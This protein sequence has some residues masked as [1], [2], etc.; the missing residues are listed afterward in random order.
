MP[1]LPLTRKSVN[2]DNILLDPNN[3]RFL[4]LEDW[5]E[6]PINMY[7]LERIQNTAFQRLDGADFAQIEDLRK[8]IRANGYIPLEMIVVKPYEE[9][10]SKYVVIEG[11]RRITAIRGIV[12]DSV[13]PDEDS[14]VQSLRT[15]E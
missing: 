7:H 5:Q 9:D 2:L 11:N 14:L 12:K 3:P 1:S 15:L 8:S 13:N 6:I 10:D 4:E